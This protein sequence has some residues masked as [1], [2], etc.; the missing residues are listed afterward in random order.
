MENSVMK[1][2]DC[3]KLVGVVI[4]IFLFFL[5]FWN[6]CFNLNLKWGLCFWYD[7]F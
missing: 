2:I 5:N 4:F 6:I 3:W 7:V 1:L